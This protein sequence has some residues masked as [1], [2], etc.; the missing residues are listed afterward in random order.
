MGLF[1]DLIQQSQLSEHEKRATTLEERV[2]RL[3]TELEAVRELLRTLLERL[4]RAV[5]EDLDRDGRVG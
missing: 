3:E 5:G 2:A 4:E 1:W